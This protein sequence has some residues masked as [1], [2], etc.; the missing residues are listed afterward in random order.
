MQSPV[1]A[2]VFKVLAAGELIGDKLPTA[3]NRIEA[4]GLIGRCIAASLAGASIYKAAGKPL[5]G[6]ALLGGITAVGTTYGAFNLRKWLR[7]ESN[8]YDPYLGLA[9]DALA[10]GTACALTI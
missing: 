3:P 2:N 7:K 4:S 10:I 6:G 9:E 5:L 8:I 1:T